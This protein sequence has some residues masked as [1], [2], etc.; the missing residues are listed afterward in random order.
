L[1]FNPTIDH[2]CT[3]QNLKLKATA[4]NNKKVITNIKETQERKGSMGTK[5]GT[6]G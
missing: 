5:V 6:K 3:S 1:N 4:N 2:K